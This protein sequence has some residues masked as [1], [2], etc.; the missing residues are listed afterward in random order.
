MLRA[1]AMPGIQVFRL[2]SQS[3]ATDALPE[4]VAEF[5]PY[6]AFLVFNELEKLAFDPLLFCRILLPPGVPTC[7][8]LGNYISHKEHSSSTNARG[9]GFGENQSLSVT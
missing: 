8:I 7:A 1:S 6:K 5:H 4:I 3:N 9:W 2:S